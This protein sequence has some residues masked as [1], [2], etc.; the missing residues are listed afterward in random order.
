MYLISIYFDEK[1]NK[2][3]QGYMD[4]VASATG[5]CFMTGNRVPPHITV[6]AFETKDEEGLLQCM[7]AL[8]EKL[9]S[10]MPRK[11]DMESGAGKDKVTM[12]RAE[13][14]QAGMLEWVTVGQFFPSVMYVAPVLNSYLHEL[15]VM[16]YESIGELEGVAVS[17]YYRPLHWLPHCTIGKTLTKEEMQTAFGALQNQFGVFTGNVVRIELAKKNPYR[18]IWGMEI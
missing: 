15:S 17:K 2:R 10:W 13:N 6:S 8:E 12:T 1:T 16:V 3:I 9:E 7:K 11:P 4:G 5:N 18:V 14:R